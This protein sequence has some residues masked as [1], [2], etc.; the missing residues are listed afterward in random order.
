MRI[1]YIIDAYRFTKRCLSFAQ[2]MSIFF[3][4]FKTA[5][6]ALRILL[7]RILNTAR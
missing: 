2:M 6:Q 4:S 1:V 5:H 3:S 7:V